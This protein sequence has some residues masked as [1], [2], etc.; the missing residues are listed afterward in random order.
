MVVR[1]LTGSCATGLLFTLN[2]TSVMTNA[3][4]RFKGG[5]CNDVKNG[6]EV[7][8]KGTRQADDKVLALRIEIDDGRRLTTI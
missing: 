8:V 6:V 4:T 1:N 3:P 5:A 2:G 7:E